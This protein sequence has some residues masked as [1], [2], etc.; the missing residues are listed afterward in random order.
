MNKVKPE[1]T[2]KINLLAEISLKLSVIKN[3]KKNME[4]QE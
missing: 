4:S 1:K 2:L 3:N